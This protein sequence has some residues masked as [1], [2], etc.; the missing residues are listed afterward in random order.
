MAI[1]MRNPRAAVATAYADM[2]RAMRVSAA[3]AFAVL[4]AHWALVMA[5]VVPRIGTLR[6]LRLHYTASQGVDWV[7][8]WYA[9]FTFPAIGLLAFFGNLAFATT[10]AKGNRQMGRM[11]LVA[12]VL[13]ELV[14]A[15]GG[16]IA[17]LLNG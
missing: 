5:F 16:V 14:L 10:L 8:E 1:R 11:V 9:I 12:T 15:A 3:L 2:D 13:I 17:V 6:F 7:G 4:A